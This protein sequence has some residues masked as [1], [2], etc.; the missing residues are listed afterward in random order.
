MQT[1]TH[2]LNKVLFAFA[3]FIITW[4]I[5]NIT[6]PAEPVPPPEEEIQAPVTDTSVPFYPNYEGKE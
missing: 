2:I 1:R 4:A 6:K 5:Y 3:L